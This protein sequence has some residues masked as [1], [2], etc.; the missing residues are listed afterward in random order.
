M[1][2]SHQLE[3][4]RVAHALEAIERNAAA[5]ATIIDD[6][7]DVSRIIANKLK[8]AWEPVDL[9]AVVRAAVNE[10]RPLASQKG[11][12]L[13][14]AANPD[15]IGVV[16]GDAERLQQVI[17]NL[18]TN[19]IKF[20]PDGGRVEVRLAHGDTDVTVQVSD[21]GEGIDP[22]FLP[23][24]FERFR[25]SDASAARRQGGLGLGLAI[26]SQIVELHGG[27]VQASSEGKG[28]GATFTV[29]LPV[30]TGDTPQRRTPA[31][32]T[33]RSVTPP[34]QTAERLDG[35][36]VLVVDDN[37]DGRTLTAL[38]LSQRGATVN[39]VASA[40]EA[41]RAFQVEAP[42]VLVTDIGLPDE[43][44]YM[45]L[46][47][48]RQQ[49]AGHAAFIPVIALTGYGGDEHRRRSLAAGFQC[50]I[51]KPFEP[52]ELIRAIASVARARP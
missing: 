1:I 52:A 21:T 51:V 49:Q 15:A 35:V 20:T 2:M 25:Q 46:R 17:G 41:L 7:L 37:L 27:T 44:G 42:D 11:I 32:A 31:A 39:A 13:Q 23:H 47:Q 29:R 5:L 50:H 3:G 38:L 33:R 19:G 6:L 48:L 40:R 26:V 43:D 24:V 45:L 10:V 28:R 14:C 4:P 30:A 9:N 16:E 18:L 8:I 34:A 22:A 12:D 36:R